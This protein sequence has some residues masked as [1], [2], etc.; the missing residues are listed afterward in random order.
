MQTRYFPRAALI[1]NLAFGGNMYVQLEGPQRRGIGDF[2]C[3]SWTLK[4]TLKIHLKNHFETWNPFN[5]TPSIWRMPRRQRRG[6]GDVV[7]FL[8]LEIDVKNTY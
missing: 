7:W 5:F 3:G 2:V 8:N 1:L 6:I 4:S